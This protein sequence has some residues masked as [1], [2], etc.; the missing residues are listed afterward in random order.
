MAFTRNFLKSLGLSDEVVQAVIEEHT[1]VTD[2]LKKFKEDAEKLPG[3]QKELDALKASAKDNDD[4]KAKYD[5]EHTAFEK[6][7]TDTETANTNAKIREAYKSLLKANNVDDKRIEAIMKVTDFSSK[8]LNKDGKLFDEDKLS[9]EI[10][11]E[12]S[13]FVVK[14][15]EQGTGGN[16]TPPESQKEKVSADAQYIRAKAAEKHV[17][18]F[19]GEMKGDK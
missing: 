4:W 5:E 18:M 7:K 3:V 13:E 10:K 6:F 17:S 11:K 9:E 16:E 14:T 2:V 15:K 12:W 19:G 8:K 1:A